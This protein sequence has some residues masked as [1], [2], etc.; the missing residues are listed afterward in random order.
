[1]G[2]SL[3]SVAGLR[4]FLP[5]LALSIA[6]HEHWINLNDHFAWLQSDTALI[7]LGVAAMVELI[8]DKIPVIDHGLDALQ[9]VV[10]PGAGLLAVASTQSH[11]DPVMAGVMGLILGAP[12]AGTVHVAKGGLRLAST[13]TTVGLANPLLSFVEDCFSV[14]LSVLALVAPI[15]AFLLVAVMILVLLRLWFRV[16]RRKVHPA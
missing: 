7:V 15:I 6:A 11:M 12:L 1:M 4:A 16:R 3:A 8:G 14:M 5:L 10:R 13:A 9:T 2:L